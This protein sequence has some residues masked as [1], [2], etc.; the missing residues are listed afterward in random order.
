MTVS[1][2]SLALPEVIQVDVRSFGDDR[3]FFKEL[4]HQGKYAEHISCEFKQDNMSYSKKGVIRGLHYQL[5]NPQAKLVSVLKG[6]VI[7]VAVDIR[8]GSP[9]FGQ[10]VAVE[11]SED[12]GR[13]LFVPEGFAHGFSVLSDDAIFLYKCSDLYTPGDEYGVVYNDPDLSIDWQVAEPLVSEKD[14][15][16]SCLKDISDEY[17]PMYTA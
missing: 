8:K 2:T 11:L 13:Q 15:A 1:F 9:R 7:D 16:C 17:L 5:K 3:G 14:A 10:A 4:Y 6:C 12:N